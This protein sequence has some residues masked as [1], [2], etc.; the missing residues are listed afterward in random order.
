MYI[1]FYTENVCSNESQ[2]LRKNGIA[3]A[4]LTIDENGVLFLLLYIIIMNNFFFD[5][6]SLFLSVIYHHMIWPNPA[7]ALRAQT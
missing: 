3:N 6:Y 1:F 7:N 5:Y 4:I 2:V